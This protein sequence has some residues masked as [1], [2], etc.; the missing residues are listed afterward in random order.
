[1][2]ALDTRLL[3]YFWENTKKSDQCWTWNGP[4]QTAGYG[5]IHRV[6]TD[7]LAHRFSYMAH[8][9]NIPRGLDVDHQCHT[10]ENCPGGRACVHRRCV[11]PDHL[12]AVTRKVN[13]NRGIHPN[14]RKTHCPANH[15]F[16]EENTFR[17]RNG[18][19]GCRTCM[20]N[21]GRENM[22]ARRA[23]AKNEVSNG[24]VCAA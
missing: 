3:D 16:T 7:T 5:R 19:R 20:R 24:F 9:G 4:V 15:E 22:R 23:R 21:Q 12:K 14:S 11:N 13:L 8:R 6:G 10:S 17:Y 1:M 18:R 2:D